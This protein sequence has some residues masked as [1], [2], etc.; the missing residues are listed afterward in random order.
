MFLILG[1]FICCL[2]TKL[3]SNSLTTQWTLA[4]QAPLSMA[5]SRQEPGVGLLVLYPECLPE[6]G[7]E[8]MSPA[9][10]GGF[11]TTEPPGVSRS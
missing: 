1:C 7:I 8:S 3:Y 5:F 11:F 6:L 4:H 2:V 9:L 10:V